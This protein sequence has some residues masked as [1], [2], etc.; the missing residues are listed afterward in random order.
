MSREKEIESAL[1]ALERAALDLWGVGD[2]SG[3][4]KIS[5]PDIVY[6]DPFL[7]GTGRAGCAY[8]LIRI[9][10]RNNSHRSLRSDRTESTGLR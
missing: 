5:A 6:F 2:P 9:V 3:Y 4:L 7:E 1:I 10:A 8:R